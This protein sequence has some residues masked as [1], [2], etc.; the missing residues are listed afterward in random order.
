MLAC[1]FEV[2]HKSINPKSGVGVFVVSV[3]LHIIAIS[4]K[5]IKH[6]LALLKKLIRCSVFIF[7]WQSRVD[8]ISVALE[9]VVCNKLQM[10][11]Q[12]TTS[13][14]PPSAFCNH[15]V[16]VCCCRNIGIEHH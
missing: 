12:C 2:I 10:G 6:S 9:T 1:L 5:R 15:D 13:E 8:W 14:L 7:V 3:F 16:L 4:H 11:T